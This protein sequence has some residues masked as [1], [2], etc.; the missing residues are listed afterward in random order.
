MPFFKH[1]IPPYGTA[2][3]RGVHELQTKLD[4]NLLQKYTCFYSYLPFFKHNIPPYGRAQKRGVPELQ[5]KLNQNLLQKY[6]C[7]CQFLKGNKGK[8]VLIITF[9]NF[10]IAQFCKQFRAQ[11]DSLFLNL[12]LFLENL[13][14]FRSFWTAKLAPPESANPPREHIG[15]SKF[16]VFTK[17]V[18][19]QMLQMLHMT[20]NDR[21]SARASRQTLQFDV[22]HRFHPFH[23]FRKI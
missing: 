11:L 7:F 6:M 2:Q 17:R 9:Q 8:L 22:L 1:N 15:S 20:P 5:T 10:R 12:N 3:K 21:P 23:F 16:T 4:R 19:L 18:M 13:H 14:I